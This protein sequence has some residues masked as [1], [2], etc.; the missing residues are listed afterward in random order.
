MDSKLAVML[1][2]SWA[3]RL[4]AK[5]MAAAEWVRHSCEAIVWTIA[6]RGTPMGSVARTNWASSGLLADMKERIWTAS[7]QHSSS[8]ISH[9]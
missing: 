5:V 7:S 3:G 8:R 9:H 2:W 6:W 1:A 4:W